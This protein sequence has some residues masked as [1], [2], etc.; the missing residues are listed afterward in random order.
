MKSVVEMNFKFDD[1]KIS[2]LESFGLTKLQANVFLGTHLMGVITVKNIINLCKMHKVEVYRVLNELENIG[3]VD[4]IMGHPVQYRAKS[5]E[6]ALQNILL[7]RIKELSRINEETAKVIEWLHSLKSYEQGN[8][9]SEGNGFEIFQG[10]NALKKMVEMG[11]RSSSIIL[12]I[13]EISD[14]I[15]KTDLMATLKLAIKRGVKIRG[16][17]NLTMSKLEIVKKFPQNRLVE[18]RHSTK[19]YSCMIIVDNREIIFSSAPK[20]LPD[21]EFIYTRNKKFIEHYLKTFDNLFKEAI[22]ISKRIRK[23]KSES[24]KQRIV[25]LA[26]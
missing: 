12:Y 11:G 6:E 20:A 17:I 5:P 13:G 15:L 21:E 22:P 26:T 2:Q 3:V 8:I 1:K 4:K 7:P 18:R 9:D 19:V 24:Q 25:Q 14:D 23:L 10:K 16:I